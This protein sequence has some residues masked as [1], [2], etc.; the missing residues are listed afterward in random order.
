M[1]DVFETVNWEVTEL[2]NPPRVKNF[3]TMFRIIKVERPSSLKAG[4]ASDHE[5]F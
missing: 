4:I 5:S 1:K 3:L 2:L